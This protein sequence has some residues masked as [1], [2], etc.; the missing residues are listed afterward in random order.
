MSFKHDFEPKFIQVS[1]GNKILCSDQALVF[2]LK[3]KTRKIKAV[4]D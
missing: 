3:F 1:V 4:Q 2:K